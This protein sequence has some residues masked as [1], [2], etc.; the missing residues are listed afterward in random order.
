MKP[1]LTISRVLPEPVEARAAEGFEARFLAQDGAF[2]AAGFLAALDGAAAALITPADRLD[3]AS[4]A[5]IPA[6]LRV[7]AT[8]SVGTDH[9]DLDAAKARGLAVVNTPDVLSFATA[10]LALTLMLAAARRAAE[11]ERIVRAR[12]W[13]GWTPTY[14]LGTS[15][16]GKTLGILGM[17]R[18]GQALARMAQGL[19]M[20]VVYHNRRRLKP[21]QEGG[22]AFIADEADFLAAA[23][24]LSIHLPGGAATLHWLNAARIARLKPGAIVINTGRGTTIDDEALAASLASGHLG[25]AGL[26]VF[27]AEPA[28]PEIYLGLENVVLL[29]HLGSAT[30][31]TRLAMGMLALDGIEAILAGQSPVNRVV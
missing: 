5:R 31:E 17:G 14:L 10:E 2:D 6:S 26:D 8:F 1:G 23:D 7:L 18:I 12:A 11:G 24:V 25:A 9:I 21:E 13:P 28:V 4:I 22:A 27:P 30:R 16:Q 15:L 29:P 20:R 3:A 19:S